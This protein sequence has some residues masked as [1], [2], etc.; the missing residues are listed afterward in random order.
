MTR[1]FNIL[2]SRIPG[3][4]HRI[5]NPLLF[6]P[7]NGQNLA[8]LEPEKMFVRWSQFFSR[9]CSSICHSIFTDLQ[10]G[11]CV[12]SGF[13]A[14]Y[15][16]E[17]R[18]LPLKWQ[19]LKQWSIPSK[20]A[21]AGPMQAFCRHWGLGP[22]QT[23]PKQAQ[24]WLAQARPKALGSPW[25]LCK[26]PT[27]ADCPQK[28]HAGPVWAAHS[29]FPRS[30]WMHLFIHLIWN[31][32]RLSIHNSAECIKIHFL[33]WIVSTLDHLKTHEQKKKPIL[34]L[35]KYSSIEAIMIIPFLFYIF[36]Y[37]IVQPC[38]CWVGGEPPGFVFLLL[39]LS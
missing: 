25:A 2:P 10:P 36:L 33:N 27:I 17:H 1:C 21:P 11:V 28:A 8:D 37:F 7:K 35:K 18:I 31:S 30:V 9:Q 20:H 4:N 15:R 12:L 14:I 3:S 26:Q 34:S 38:N 24:C 6:V 32:K 19:L 39:F 22:A 23:K 16:N 5:L 13:G 29:H